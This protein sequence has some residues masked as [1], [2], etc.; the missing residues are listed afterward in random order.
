MGVYCLVDTAEE[1]AKEIALAKLYSI[2]PCSAICDSAGL[3]YSLVRLMM[4]G[5][6]FFLPREEKKSTLLPPLMFVSPLAVSCC[7]LLSIMLL[8]TFPSFYP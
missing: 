3:A 8:L 5:G 1:V 2:C 4:I 7:C 6:D